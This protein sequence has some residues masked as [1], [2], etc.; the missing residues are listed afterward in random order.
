MPKIPLLNDNHNHFF[1]YGMLANAFN[2]QSVSSKNRAL[3]LIKK[4]SGDRVSVVLGWN[5]SYYRFTST[6][7]DNL[8]PVVICN[9]SLHGFIFNS[10][11]REM[12]RYRGG[13][14][15]DQIDN[16]AWC[17]KN[18]TRILGF[19][20]SI[21][22][23]DEDR[24]L[25]FLS[26]MEQKGI[27]ISEDMFAPDPEYIRF[28]LDSGLVGRIFP[29]TD[30]DSYR[31]LPEQFKTSM[32]G[33]KIFTDGALGQRTAALKES[34][35]GGSRGLLNHT[36]AELDILIGNS[37]N[38]CDSISIH[39]IG[40]QAIEQV[41]DIIPE[42]RRTKNDAVIRIEHC[43]FINRENAIRAKEL[44]IIL[45]MQPNFSSDSVV[46]LDRLP[47][48]YAE[49]NNP[50]RMLIDEAGFIP[51]ADLI[52]GSD[53]MPHGIQFALEQ[54]F[55]PPYDSQKLS[56]DEL[57]SGY[58][59]NNFDSGQIDVIIDRKNRRVQTRV[60]LNK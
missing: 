37:L 12:L 23:L 26:D 56:L 6:E 11:A 28:L 24:M 60:I 39:A 30:L 50:F 40:D 19:L 16:P 10:R 20:A 54:S 32:R 2:L 35:R 4:N 22:P 9:Q 43:Q 21:E 8:P 5:D 38:L 17:E 44:G 25:R 49:K 27:W 53:G 55:F 15:V 7:L 46:Y 59:M 58:C 52:F 3:E 41:L 1:I 48:G 31:K 14:I 18:L 29:W 33:I 34:Y 36:P 42:H 45:S 51:G 57:V 13:Q 47:E